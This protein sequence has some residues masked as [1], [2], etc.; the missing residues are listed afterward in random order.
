VAFE[1]E[2][3]ALREGKPKGK[4]NSTPNRPA[5][6][7][8]PA[9]AAATVGDDFD[10]MIKGQQVVE[11]VYQGGDTSEEEDDNESNSSGSGGDILS[12]HPLQSHAIEIDFDAMD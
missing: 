7:M 6:A 4:E 12:S 5:A 11:V 10:L 2:A 9:P 1:A 8:A 3:K